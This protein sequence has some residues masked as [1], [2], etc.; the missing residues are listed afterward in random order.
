MQSQNKTHIILR[1]SG[2]DERIEAISFRMNVGLMLEK[3]KC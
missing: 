3:E 1:I 2:S